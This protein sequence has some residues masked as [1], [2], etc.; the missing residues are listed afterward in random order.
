MTGTRSESGFTLL[1]VLIAIV[2]TAMIGIGANEIL[3]QAIDI[4]QKTR[5]RLESLSQL[6]KAMLILS[7]DF[8][9]TVPRSIRDEYGDFQPA[10]STRN[11]DHRV[12]LT[13]AGWRNPL[14]DLRSDLQ[15]V[16]YTLEDGQLKRLHWNTLDRTH[17]NAPIERIL[18]RDVDE[19]QFRFLN[20]SNGWLD[21]WPSDQAGNGPA[22]SDPMAQ[23]NRLPKAVEF[24]F[25]H[26]EFGELR[27]V[28]DLVSWLEGQPVSDTESKPDD[29]AGGGS[30]P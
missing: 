24:R 10:F 14:G 26:R 7:R 19:L 5:T 21:E 28:F 15:R 29:T 11:T 8:R 9:Q 22:G 12:E 16:A 6:Q 30:E 18:L 3:G 2:I 4:S 13:R 25:R 1:E 23:Y 27:R 20:D 17:D